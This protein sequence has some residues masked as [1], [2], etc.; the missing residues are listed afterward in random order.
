MRSGGTYTTDPIVVITGD[1]TGATA[2][3]H[4]NN[5]LLSIIIVLNGGSGYTIAPTVV[6]G[7]GSGGV[8]TANI[9]GGAVVSIT[10]NS[11]GSGYS[12]GD[13]ISL[14]GGDGVGATAY[15]QRV[16]SG[17]ISSVTVTNPGSGYSTA[18]VSLSG[19]GL[20]EATANPMTGGIFSITIDTPQSVNYG[21]SPSAIPTVI[22]SGG[23]GSGVLTTVVLAQA[24]NLSIEEDNSLTLPISPNLPN[25][26]PNNTNRYM[27]V[28]YTGGGAVAPGLGGFFSNI[29]VVDEE[30]TNFGQYR[31]GDRIMF[32]LW[33]KI[34]IGYTL[35]T[36][37]NGT[38]VGAAEYWLTP[39][40]GT[41]AWQQYIRIRVC[42]EEDNFPVTIFSNTGHFY[43]SG[44]D[45]AMDWAVGSCSAYAIDNINSD[46]INALNIG[47]KLDI[48]IP[49]G[50]LLTTNQSYLAT[51]LGNVY[52]GTD[53]PI[54]TARL[55]IN[56]SSSS[57]VVMKLFGASSQTANLLE[58]RSD[59]DA[60]LSFVNASGRLALGSTTIVANAMLQINSTDKG[61]LIP[62][63]TD[64]QRNS[65]SSP[66]SGLTVYTTDENAY[67]YWNGTAWVLLKGFPI[68]VTPVVGTGVAGRV[69]FW[70]GTSTIGENSVFTWDNSN[71]RLGI[72]TSSADFTLDVGGDIRVEG[73][74]KI[75]FGGTG[76]TGNDVNLY[77]SGADILK[78]DD[79]LYVTGNFTLETGDFYT[80]DQT[81]TFETS[82]P[83]GYVSL[84]LIPNGT[85]QLTA[86][87]LFNDSDESNS[88]IIQVN[89]RSDGSFPTIHLTHIGSGTT[90][91]FLVKQD[92]NTI[93]Y[94]P[95]GGVGLTIGDTSTPGAVL[96]AVGTT[97]S[98]PVIMATGAVSQT[99]DVA[100]WCSYGDVI[101]AAITSNGQLVF[102]PSGSQDTTLYRSAANT[103]KTDGVFLAATGIGIN[104]VSLL[105]SAILQIDSTIKGF[106]PP[107]MNNTQRDAISSPATGLVLYS[108]TDNALEFWN[109]SSWLVGIST[110]SIGGTIHKIPKWTS[111]T[112]LG[113]SIMTESG[114]S[115]NISGGITAT[116][117]SFVI[118]HPTKLNKK[119]V[120]GSL[121]G[122]EHGAY[123]RGRIQGRGEI[124]V[125]LPEYWHKLV[126]KAYTIHLTAHGN[127]N[128]YVTDQD[129][130]GFT[131]RRCG[132]LINRI[133]LVD[134]SYYVV[135]CRLDVSLEIEQDYS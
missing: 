59:S 87:Q 15:I 89:S 90:P 114:G 132:W 68:G 25:S 65:I 130:N 92:S 50:G 40:T 49:Y 113:D 73:A 4:I 133:L 42:G 2:D 102:G 56:S 36:A 95:F 35:Q 77:R 52:I 5:G 126:Q 83:D 10:I 93:L 82:F 27:K 70:T 60:I 28:S 24:V 67:S 7:G 54:S 135:G 45:V 51:N 6:L 115:I 31:R 12:V 100:Q 125:E 72:G 118:P 22:L 3:A 84:A 117:K 11:F 121:E 62:R 33:A 76:P 134:F 19:G 1:G 30:V 99:A 108:T 116:S 97:A 103:L 69:A 129:E 20:L 124:R 101:M 9:S 39:Q 57:N 18:V 46:T 14:V 16:I 123:H 8:A 85:S 94:S 105:P 79:N 13:P 119:L 55:T 88:G 106:L 64:A 74:N 78:T 17:S 23:G 131:V 47:N 26:V 66:S 128:V 80:S 32:V 86:I 104:A 96:H 109:G 41:G 71:S 63:M 21:Y 91:D 44:P 110:P 112:S 120:Y 75:Y 107:R 53:T 34:P 48:D 122:P 81:Y 43:L 127:Y 38:G 98:T 111:S 37:S 29:N 61:I 58:L